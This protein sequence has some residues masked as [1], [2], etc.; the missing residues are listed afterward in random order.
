MR[1]AYTMGRSL[2]AEALVTILLLA[3]ILGE[4]GALRCP[5]VTIVSRKDW[6]ARR[7]RLQVAM[8]NPRA[9]YV[10][11]HHTTGPQCKDKSSCSR[12]IR[13]HQNHHMNANR[14][15]D[16]GYNFLVGGDGRIYE[17][18][19][20]GR[21]GA[22]TRGYNQIGIAISFLEDF[23]RAIPSLRM[24]WAVKRLIACGVRQGKIDKRYTLRGHRDANCTSCPGNLLYAIIKKWAHFKG[25]LKRFFC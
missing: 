4:T 22:H 11:I 12:L 9:Q 16:I 25:R 23:K 3:G 13:S 5:G 14:W 15:P 1:R 6:G 20:F 21:E 8:R 7:P 2:A 18:R 17:G 10:F 19:G 24:R